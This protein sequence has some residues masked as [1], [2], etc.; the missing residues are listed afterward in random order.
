LISSTSAAAQH[1][2][3]AEQVG[4]AL[5]LEGGL[6]D[7]GAAA[8]HCRS[9]AEAEVMGIARDVL[10]NGDQAGH[11]AAALIFRT[12]GVA[13]ALRRDHQHVEI[14][15]RIEQVEVHVEAVCEDERCALLHV[16]VHVVAIDVALQFVRGEHHHQVGP[17]GG[18][19]DFHHLEAG[20]FRLLR[21]GRALAQRND[22]V[23][24]AGV[25]E[26]Q[27]MGMALA[28]VADDADLLALDQVQVGVFV[29]ENFHDLPKI[30]WVNV[31][32]VLKL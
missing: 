17:L 4:L 29:V 15:A 14:F 24:D 5:F 9:V 30:M 22:H 13:G 7:A 10:V 28:A 1:R 11:A 32:D 26:V 12:H 21:G 25:L 8:T 3:L 16:V 23:L 18:L 2:L 31:M 27:R 20:G 19:G 6:D